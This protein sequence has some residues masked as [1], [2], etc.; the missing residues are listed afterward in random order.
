M[1]LPL[2]VSASATIS[3]LSRSSAY[4][5]FKRRFWSS[6]SFMRAIKDAS[7]PPCLARHL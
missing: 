2:F 1:A 3:A 5:F 6:S 7:M 4:I